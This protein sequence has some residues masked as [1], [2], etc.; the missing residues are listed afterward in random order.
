M[1]SEMTIWH[2]QKLYHDDDAYYA[3]LPYA[4]I[5]TVRELLEMENGV[6]YIIRFLKSS[7]FTK[8]TAESLS[9]KKNNLY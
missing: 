3:V 1:G 5:P 9:E 2:M 6:R 8:K 4:F 7:H